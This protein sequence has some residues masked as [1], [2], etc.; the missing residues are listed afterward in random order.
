[1]PLLEIELGERH[2][3]RRRGRRRRR[4]A[5]RG[6]RVDLVEGLLDRLALDL[7]ADLARGE[8]R[9]EERGLGLEG[10]RRLRLMPGRGA[11]GRRDDRDRG[12][13]GRDRRRLGRRAHAGPRLG[14]PPARRAGPARLDR[15]RGGPPGRRRGHRLDGVAV[16]L[17]RSG[18]GSGSTARPARQATAGAATAKIASRRQA[19]SQPLGRRAGRRERAEGFSPRPRGPRR[20]SE[21]ERRRRD[22]AQLAEGPGRRRSRLRR[23]AAAIRASAGAASRLADLVVAVAE[24]R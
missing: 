23:P 9:R 12:Q 6:G 13:R 17:A 5:R 8:R 22:L 16:A 1:M 14:R 2:A 24:Q 10:A 19:A 21:R 4:D 11:G 18:A 3:R 7:G 15:R 20:G